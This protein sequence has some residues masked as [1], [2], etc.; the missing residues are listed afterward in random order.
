[1]DMGGSDDLWAVRTV[2]PRV[3]FWGRGMAYIN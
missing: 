2:R 3:N 1:M